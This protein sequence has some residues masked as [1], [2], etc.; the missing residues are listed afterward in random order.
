MG[1][2][3]SVPLA[4]RQ[5]SVVSA[6]GYVVAR[7]EDHAERVL[8]RSV[9][10][11]KGSPPLPDTG[12]RLYAGQARWQPL[13]ARFETLEPDERLLPIDVT[14][15]AIMSVRILDVDNIG[16]VSMLNVERLRQEYVVEINRWLKSRHPHR[17]ID[18]RE[19]FFERC[20]DLVDDLVAHHPD[21]SHLVA[22]CYSARG[23]IGDG[24]ETGIQ[25]VNILDINC[26]T[27]IGVQGD[28]HLVVKPV[29]HSIGQ[30]Q[31]RAA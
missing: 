31:V 15:A 21:W 5:T 7:A 23:D 22:V 6:A 10:S 3:T 9:P 16:E 2:R 14:Y 13:H 17:T 18:L 11:P 28:R 27:K 30:G 12:L 20:P 8:C 25:F 29:W 4:R 24:R 19:P 1:H 26:I